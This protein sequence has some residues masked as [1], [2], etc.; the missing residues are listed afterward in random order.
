MYLELIVIVDVSVVIL[1]RYESPVVLESWRSFI[2]SGA[3]A[4]VESYESIVSLISSSKTF[5]SS[6]F[7]ILEPGTRSNVR[8][9]HTFLSICLALNSC[10]RFRSILFLRCSRCVELRDPHV[11]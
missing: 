9:L 4:L 5:Q 10:V 6:S 1:G 7:R 8:H 3:S 2:I 11:Y